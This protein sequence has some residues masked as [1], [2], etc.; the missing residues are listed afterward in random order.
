MST[1]QA[2]KFFL[3]VSA[4]FLAITSAHTKKA[5][6]YARNQFFYCF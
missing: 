2:S 5:Q 6:N 4:T 1:R 3:T